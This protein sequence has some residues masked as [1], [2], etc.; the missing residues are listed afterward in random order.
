MLIYNLRT[1]FRER[2]IE[3][4]FSFLVKAGIAP[5]TAH[6]ILSNNTRSCKLR[7]IEL[8]CRLLL[9]EPS[10][11]FVW[12]PDK[13]VIYPE[14]LPL[15]RLQRRMGTEELMSMISKLPLDELREVT[16]LIADREKREES[17][18]D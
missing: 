13:G 16:E 1:L 14:N 7:H 17:L 4:P 8:L 2:G 10:D 11:L 6:N 3:R 12:A 15:K 9:C 5:A 18:N